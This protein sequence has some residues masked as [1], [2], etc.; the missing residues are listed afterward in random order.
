MFRI[1]SNPAWRRGSARV[2]ADPF[3]PLTGADLDVS[4]GWKAVCRDRPY[5]SAIAN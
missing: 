1:K 2:S 3:P 5:H 4:G